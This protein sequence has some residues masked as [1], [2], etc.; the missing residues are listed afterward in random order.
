[1]PTPNQETVKQVLAIGDRAALIRGAVEDSWSKVSTEFADL[2][3]WRRKTT[4]AALVWEYAVQAAIEA[5]AGDPGVRVVRHHD[6]VSFVIDETVLIRFKKANIE[7]KSSNYP[8]F[9]AQLF[10]DHEV[11]DLFGLGELQRVEAAYVLNR[12][13]T[14]IVWVGMVARDKRQVS[15]NFELVPASGAEII[16]LP[17]RTEP[18]APAADAVIQPRGTATSD[19]EKSGKEGE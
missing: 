11:P 3:W 15:W 10:H 14:G 4:R 5:L 13:Q 9:L 12:F 1:M 6:T 17:T 2:A 18:V 7:L 8:T 19:D 16:E